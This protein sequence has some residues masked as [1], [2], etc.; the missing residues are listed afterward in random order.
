MNPSHFNRLFSFCMT[1]DARLMVVS[2][3]ILNTTNNSEEVIAMKFSTGIQSFMNNY[4]K[5]IM[6]DSAA[7]FA[8]AGLSVPA[9]FVPWKELLRE[10]AMDLGLDVEKETDLVTLAQYFYNKNRS[11]QELAELI[12]QY[13][14][15]E[16][17]ITRN[18]NI[19]ASLPIRTYW[20]TNYDQLIEKA[21]IQNGKTPD[22]KRRI[23]DFSIIK[24]RRDAIVY[25][26]HGD[27]ELADQAI[28]IKDDYE[29]YEEKNR[30]F[31]MNL[32]GELVSK[33]FL[34]IGFSFDDPNLEHILSRI[35]ALVDGHTR[36][37]YC[38]FKKVQRKDYP[39]GEIG[40]QEY[41]YDKIKQDLKCADLVR[42]CIRPI[43]ID[44]YS[45]IEHIL[46]MLYQRYNR[47]NVLISG[48]ASE[49]DEFMLKDTD[50]TQFIHDLSYQ[51]N[52][53]KY[54]V[55]SGFGGGVGN[56][57]ING[58]LES[59][60]ESNERKIDNHLL[61]R[62]LPRYTTD[63]EALTERWEKYRRDLIREAGIA[64]F[65]FGNKVQDNQLINSPGV[66]REFEIAK[67]MG[68]KLIPIGVT[69]Y[70]SQ[71]L[72]EEVMKKF[73]QLYGDFPQLQEEFEKLGNSNMKSGEVI[74][75]VIHI[76][77]VLNG[78]K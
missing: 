12:I 34:F 61:L 27:V 50:P 71:Q 32:K 28:L 76:I 44:D 52:K 9:G 72:W 70:A 57:V 38:F 63:E 75:A 55:V 8:G 59:V 68:I 26:M 67:E 18:H 54:K 41:K 11:R 13:F 3:I 43:L 51:L 10:P 58:V 56:Y 48:S 14:D 47:N 77:D 15:R 62:P 21:L 35:R 36:T 4:L 49:Y 64:I 39:Q 78:K 45:D 40:E 74:Q 24:P 60:Y 19:L 37:H 23:Q 65:I 7:I 66:K 17:V 1:N 69:G 73:D 6:E 30:L 2:K 5:A 46:T 33:T 31:T 42:Y 16:G 20:T 29:T 25:K 53:K 22:V